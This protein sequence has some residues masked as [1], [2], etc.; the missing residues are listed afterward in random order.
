MSLHTAIRA[1]PCP[2]YRPTALV[3]PTTP[4]GGA[5]FRVLHCR[6]DSHLVSPSHLPP[7]P[8][9]ASLE[10]S[11]AETEARYGVQLA[12]L[13]GLISSIEQQLGELRC[14]ME[15]QNHEYQVL[16]DVKTRLEQEIATYR[17]LL[18][19]EDAQ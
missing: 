12:Q 1:P 14:D 7:D 13:Q 17:R 8:Q 10:G 11:L 15:R 16:L 5:S 4:H 6:E 2:G 19:G 9:K 3:A 18:E